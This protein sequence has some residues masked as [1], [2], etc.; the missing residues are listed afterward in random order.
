MSLTLVIVISRVFQITL[1]CPWYFLNFNTLIIFLRRLL[2]LCVVGGEL[3]VR[4]IACL[5]DDFDH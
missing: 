3:A 2:K 4:F 5:S 1:S